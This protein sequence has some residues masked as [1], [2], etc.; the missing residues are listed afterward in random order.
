MCRTTLG[1]L[2]ACVT[3]IACPP[4]GAQDDSPPPKAG[5]LSVET[6]A[7]EVPGLGP[8]EADFGRLTVPEKRAAPDSNLIELAFVRLRSTAESPRAP[9]VYLAGGPGGSSTNFADSPRS[10]AAWGP[11]LAVCDVV[12]LDQRATGR[13]TPDLRYRTDRQPPADVFTDEAVAKQFFAS[14]AREAAERFRKQGI[15]LTGYNSNEAADDI[16][17]LRRA[18][19]AEKISLIGFSYGT[20]LALAT[21]RRHGE[22]LENVVAIGV[23]GLDETHKL[24]LAMDVQLGKVSL[25]VARD[26][27]VGPYVPD[28][29]ALLKRVC[30]KLDRD[31]MVVT[32][33]G[34]DHQPVEV[35]VGSFGLLYILRR[36]LGDASDLPVFPRLLYSIDQGDPSVLQWFV[37]K[38]WG[39]SSLNLMTYLTDGASGASPLRWQMINQQARQSVFGDVADIPWP[40]IDEA[41]G[42]EDLGEDYRAP[43]V[44][45]VRALFL[46]G[47]LDFNTPPYQAERIRW[48]M[49]N[50]THLIVENAG[51][52]Q[53]LPQPGV[54]R[55]I[56]AFLQGQDV[57]DRT[58]ILPPLR[59]V[60]IEGFDPQVTHPSVSLSAQWLATALDEGVDAAVAEYRAFAAGHDDDA[61]GDLNQ[62]GYE[63]LGRG[64]V[65]DAIAI[66][67]LNVEEHPDSWNAFDSL[68]EGYKEAGERQR[69]IELYRRS[70][71]MN[72]DNANGIRMLESLGVKD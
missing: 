38:R 1:A 45:D 16:D 49:P 18:L 5:D 59:F 50:A 19:G 22:H 33:A 43:L 35:A 46:T 17:D 63:L 15:D 11:L 60:P 42:V 7:I 48:G 61:E 55:A 52:E 37:R 62:L 24:P 41:I 36:D 6:R 3:M 25:M 21:I 12:F 27:R 44:S 71:E 64:R 69:A 31:P 8:V 34:P 26:E 9:L 40:E 57:R 10:L 13:S 72:P 4:A 28:M 54:Q 70:L 14:V 47:T 23:E 2:I 58:V 53:I 32:I 51:H 29:A 56:L 30:R 39:F 67:S 66:F 68:A 20:H 65:Q